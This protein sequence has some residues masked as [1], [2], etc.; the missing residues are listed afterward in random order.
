MEVETPDM[1]FAAPPTGNVLGAEPVVEELMDEVEI[2][3]ETRYDMGP[4]QRELLDYPRVKMWSEDEKDVA[5][6]D[7]LGEIERMRQTHRSSKVVRR[8]WLDVLIR[9]SC[10]LW[11][12][13]PFGWMVFLGRE[14]PPVDEFLLDEMEAA[15]VNKVE[16]KKEEGVFPFVEL[17]DGG[18]VLSR[19]VFGSCSDQKKS[20][21]YWDTLARLS[22]DLTILG[23]NNVY[24]ECQDGDCLDLEKA[25]VDL[26]THPSFV[27]AKTLLP[28]LQTMDDFDYGA[29]RC[30]ESNP[31]KDVAKSLFLDFFDAPFDDPRRARD[32]GAYSARTWGPP[33]RVVQVLLLDV[34]YHRSSFLLAPA[35]D[36]SYLPDST[37][38]QKTMLGDVQWRWLAEQLALPA[39]LRLVV[40]PLQLLAEGHRSECWRML[41]FEQSRLL[42]LLS[43]AAGRTVVLS[44]NRDVGG[45]YYS[46]QYDLYE[47]TASS[48]TH[49]KTLEETAQEVGSASDQFLIGET[50]VNNF[51]RLDVNWERGQVDLTL[52]R[53]DSTLP[54]SDLESNTGEVLQSCTFSMD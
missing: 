42:E 33:G 7:Y 36:S 25:Y 32:R 51:G 6:G 30:D 8:V 12:A 44:G 34:R 37:D 24:G 1:A 35:S 43:E 48:W 27:G 14:D 29:A 41:P 3:D 46:S 49:T 54:Q 2:I 4:Y 18:Q 50:H 19:L 20:L 17:P 11:M 10:L 16:V 5:T 38:S 15:M 31:H 23:G 22:P 40:S 45:L 28:M 9:Y 13:V 26:S 39:R 53:V 47:A 52:N 21:S